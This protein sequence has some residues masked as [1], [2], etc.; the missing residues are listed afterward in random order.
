MPHKSSMTTSALVAI[1]IAS[2]SFVVFLGL[3]YAFCHCRRKHAAKKE[4]SSVGGGVGGGNANA[5]ANPGSTGA[6]E[7]DL[8]L[9]ASRRPSLSQD[10][11][12]SQQ[13]PPPPPPYYPTGTLDSKDIGNGNGGMELTLTA[14]HDPDEQLNMQQQQHHSNHGQYQQPKAILGIYGGV[15]GSGG[16][17]SG[18]QHPHSN[19]YG[20]HVT[21]AIGVDSD[22]YQVLPSVANSAAGSHGHGSGHGHGLGAGECE[23][24]QRKCCANSLKLYRNDG[25]KILRIIETL[26]KNYIFITH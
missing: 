6:K 24:M 19:G 23:Y 21:S 26:R 18:G 9:D 1:I 14:L 12:Q 5:T 8:D 25:E 4:S 11:Q 17:N 10:P 7:Y 2:L 20:Y 16:N 13:Q 22:S 3:L 15:A